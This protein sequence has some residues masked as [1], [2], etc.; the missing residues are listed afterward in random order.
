MAILPKKALLTQQAVVRYIENMHLA[1]NRLT[2]S[3]QIV[4]S[5]RCQEKSIP[6]FKKG[7][8]VRD[9][10]LGVDYT[11]SHFDCYQLNGSVWYRAHRTMDQSYE[12]VC[13]DWLVLVQKSGKWA[14]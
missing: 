7:D 9:R 10:E 12:Q 6:K 3:K 13:E 14:S 8:I 2:V 1:T 4:G 11:I 5:Q